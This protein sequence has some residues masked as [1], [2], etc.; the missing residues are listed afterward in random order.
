MISDS[1][2][3]TPPGGNILVHNSL[4]IDYTN[5][6]L[7]DSPEFGIWGKYFT[8]SIDS[9]WVMAAET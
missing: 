2:L 1:F 7:K 6:I 4:K 3:F 8:V 9:I 5:S